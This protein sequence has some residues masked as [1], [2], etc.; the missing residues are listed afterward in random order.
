MILRSGWNRIETIAKENVKS[1]V[2]SWITEQDLFRGLILRD[3]QV[4]VIL[5]FEVHREQII[6]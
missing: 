1:E 4:A 3:T 5:G 2:I 6:N